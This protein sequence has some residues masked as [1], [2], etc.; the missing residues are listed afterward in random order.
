MCAIA[1]IINFNRRVI[2]ADL[3]RKMNHQLRHRGPDDEGYGFIQPDSGVCAEY[4]GDDSPRSLQ[5][6]YPMLRHSQGHLPFTIGLAH[7]RFAIIDLSAN[8][9][10][11]FFDSDRLCCVVANGEIFN[12]PELRD[13]L[14]KYGHK[15]RSAS[16][17]EVIVEAYKA[18]GVEC[19]S[20]F[21][22]M[23]AM[24][25]YDFRSRR[26]I[27][28]RDRLGGNPALLD[29]SPGFD[30]LCLGNQSAMGSREPSFSE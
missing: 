8:A 9:H 19:F 25:L 26:L 11:P 20:R 1:G 21:N 2:N 18:W 27:L 29:K 7:R 6:T 23:W 3:L 15:F 17:V 4:S 10:Q 14:E 22:G 12:Y 30:L 13:D 16:D 28:S 24:A 5:R